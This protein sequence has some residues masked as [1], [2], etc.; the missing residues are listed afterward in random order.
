ME[1]IKIKENVINEFDVMIKQSW[2]YNKMTEKEKERWNNVLNDKQIKDSLKGKYEQRWI[3]L[4]AIYHSF[5]IGIG[6]TGWDWR[7][8]EKDPLPF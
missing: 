2:T 6:F 7:S 8:D 4:N 5:L 1:K 3:S